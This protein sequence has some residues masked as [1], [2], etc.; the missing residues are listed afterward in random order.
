MKNIKRI[1]FTFS[2]YYLVVLV[3]LAGYTPPYSLNPIVIGIAL[4]LILQIIF[5]NKG[6]GLIMGGLVI[7][8]S[9]FM[10]LPL[11]SEFSEFHTFNASS[12]QLLFVGLALIIVN[13]V[14]GG[15]MIYKN[16]LKDDK[17]NL[18]PG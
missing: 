17:P 5:K 8:I 7:L 16:W 3:L 9:L 2:E 18:L 1:L 12:A 13:I 4:I 6:V 10:I 11:L 14:V 15:V